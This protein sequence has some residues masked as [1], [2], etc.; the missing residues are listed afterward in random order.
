[1]IILSGPARGVHFPVTAAARSQTSAATH[2]VNR[3]MASFIVRLDAGLAVAQARA[4]ICVGIRREKRTG[5]QELIWRNLSRLQQGLH[6]SSS[7]SPAHGQSV[8]GATSCV[9]IGKETRLS[10]HTGGG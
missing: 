2:A 4:A 9:S 3:G 6:G 5:H 10:T 1:M 8:H 7:T